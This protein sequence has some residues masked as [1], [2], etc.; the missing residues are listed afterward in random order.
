MGDPFTVFI[1]FGEWKPD[2]GE[3]AQDGLLEASGVAPLG[4]THVPT[5]TWDSITATLSGVPK[6]YWI[7]AT[8]AGAGFVG[9]YGS[10]TKLY[11][12]NNTQN[13]PWTEAE[14]TRTVGGNYAASPAAS[15]WQGASFGDAVIM[16]NYTDDPQLLTSPAA[17]NFVKLATTAGG[18]AG[19]GMDPR[20]R[21]AFP[22][23][24]NLFLAYLNLP[25]ALLRPDGTTEL[26]AGAYPVHV[27]CSATDNVRAY[28][29]FTATP[30]LIGPLLQPLNFDLGYITGGIGGQ[31]GLVAMQRGWVRIDGP[32]YTFRP[33]SEG[34][35]CIYPNSIVRLG[36]DVYFWG[37]NGP[38]V[39]SG[40]AERAVTLGANRVIRNL[41]DRIANPTVAIKLAASP[42]YVSAAVDHV[43]GH[44]WFAYV[45]ADAASSPKNGVL[46]IY[47]TVNDRFSFGS[48]PVA[49]A[50]HGLHF[51]QTRPVPASTDILF[52]PGRDLTGI[53]F[54]PAN[55]N[56][57]A[58]AP[59][60]ALDIRP[61][62][63]TISFRRLHDELTTR[64]TRVR[65]VYSLTENSGT[66]GDSQA[67]TIYDKS[68][69]YETAYSSGPYTTID[70]DGA[71]PT[72]DTKF[73]HFHK[74]KVTMEPV[75]LLVSEFAGIEVQG[76]TG[77]KYGT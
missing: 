66:P 12:L 34:D 20:A 14:K 47:D 43:N 21:F 13:N 32:P 49:F 53:L 50:T 24:G 18:V 65:V 3:F 46:L 2:A 35:G 58:A 52:T 59:S 67:V 76:L 30:N 62:T 11:E 27:C 28:G 19:A 71:V 7:H 5:P 48:V 56:T 74:V 33:F 77:G 16:T 51:L 22:V 25:T 4:D 44:V 42:I 26:A 39:L 54:D 10:D 72:P 61:I 1:P 69:T 23:R 60:Q 37:A 73:H 41:I 70:T 6:G 63:L 68:K 36:E 40:G 29:S 8:D 38:A 55:T 75:T 15:G 45:P 57:W 17:A 64:I 31:Y 9:Y